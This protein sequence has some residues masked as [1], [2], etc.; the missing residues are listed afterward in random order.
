M[1][2]RAAARTAQD[3]TRAGPPIPPGEGPPVALSLPETEALCLKAARGAGL[4]W[5]L[6]EEAGTAAAWLAERGL[7]GAALVLD[8][9]EGGARTVPRPAEERWESPGGP[10]CPVA[11]GA[12]LADFVELPEGPSR[13]E[14][15]LAAIAVP[16]LLLPFLARAAG[17]LGR[18]LALG[19]E[20]GA[21]RIGADGALA[22]EVAALVAAGVAGRA[23]VSPCPAAPSVRADTRRAPLPLALPLWRRLDALALRTTVPPS[24]RSR[25]GAGATGDDGD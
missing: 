5:G 4:P 19:W 2:A 10:L 15:A 21:V 3:P 24:E 16:A 14:L 7:P 1:T 8:W 6:A 9:L 13:C 11:T 25:A 22:G 23:V 12:A 20:G 18:P 17:M